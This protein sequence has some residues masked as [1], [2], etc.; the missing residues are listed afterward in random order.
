M[1]EDVENAMPNRQRGGGMGFGNMQ[2]G[3]NMQGGGNMRGGGFMGGGFGGS[4]GGG[5][6]VYTDDNISS[7]SAIFDNAVFSSSSDKDK[8]RVITALENLNTG[9]DLEE[10]TD[11]DATLRYFAA[12]TVVV[13][14]DSYTSNMQQNFYLYER[15]GKITILPWDYNLSFGGFQSGDASAVVNF[16]I[17]TPVSGVSMEDR[18][19]INKLLEVDEYLDRY[20]DYLRQIVGGYFESGLFEN[21]IMALDAKINQYVMNDTTAFSTYE[22][23]E[24]ALPVFIEFGHLRAESIRGQLDGTIP[25]TSSGQNADS[26]SLVDASGVNLS[27]LGSMMGGG[28]MRQG[29]WPG[30]QDAGRDRQQPDDQNGQQG[31]QQPEDQNGQRDGQQSE[32]QNGQQGGQGRTQGG[33]EGG[34]PGGRMFDMDMDMDLM[35]QA[36]QILSNAG[37]ELTDEVRTSL[38]DLGLTEEQIEILT[39]MQNRFRGRGDAQGSGF[40]GRDDQPSTPGG[41]RAGNGTGSGAGN[42]TDNGTGNEQFNPF[43]DNAQQGMNRPDWNSTMVPAEQSKAGAGHILVIGALLAVLTGA[44]I[45]VARPGKYMI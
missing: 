9:T 33:R 19:L 23:Y 32:D 28:G 37:G 27:T 42:G 21:T 40:P 18:P 30:G 25:S 45:F 16:P 43:G 41:N 5:S 34:M 44:T 26:S 11:V 7:Y 2:G 38:T 22:Q 6:L 24:A 10:Y 17:D 8:K 20:H 36:M 35:Q 29:A 39:Q 13:N 15:D 14:L 4:S 12:H 1:W 3:D 31:G